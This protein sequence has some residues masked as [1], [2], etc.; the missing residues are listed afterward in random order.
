MKKILLLLLFCCIYNISQ[1]QD[2]QQEKTDSV[3]Q[4]V[5]KYFNEK[6]PSAIYDL[7]GELFQR[8]ISAETFKAFCKNNLFLLGEWKTAVLESNSDDASKYKVV[9]ATVN[10]TLLLG[11]NEKSKIEVFQFKPYV[12]NKVHRKEKVNSTN[13]LKS[14]LDQE[15]DRVAQSYM[16]LPV[17]T[18]LSIGVFRNGES[19]FY[20]Y[21][22]TAKENKQVPD[23]H[24]IFEIGSI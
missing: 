2:R 8:A 22:E 15:V 12:E 20:G 11:L 10:L 5:K 17:T 3:S 7:T 24:T 6:N 1:A 21:G 16:M 14:P 13:P 4:L 19:I 23:E 9:F 18:G